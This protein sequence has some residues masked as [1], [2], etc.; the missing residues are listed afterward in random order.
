MTNIGALS[1]HIGVVLAT[2]TGQNYYSVQTDDS[3]QDAYWAGGSLGELGA[4]ET[5]I[6]MPGTRVIVASQHRQ[7]TAYI[8]GVVPLSWWAGDQDTPQFR[9]AW[10]QLTGM[11]C[12]NPDAS[13]AGQLL[14]QQQF[15]RYFEM[16]QIRDLV[17]G[18]WARTSP[19]TGAGVGVE[20]FR[21][22]L[23]GGPFSG[24]FCY[25]DEQA[26]RL[27]GMN[28]ELWSLL[29][30]VEERRR[31]NALE[32]IERWSSTPQDALTDAVPRRL[33]LSGKLYNGWHDYLAPTIAR[34]DAGGTASPALFHQH[35]ASDGFLSITSATG[36][37]LQRYY[38]VPIPVE[39][40]SEFDATAAV[41]AA[42]Q[43]TKVE[44]LTK[45]QAQLDKPVPP[46]ELA[47]DQPFGWLDYV[48][49]LV[50]DYGRRTRVVT[51]A[52]DQTFVPTSRAD[53]QA[54][55]PD[56]SVQWMGP[57]GS[58]VIQLDT[59]NVG[60]KIRYGRSCFSLLPDGS[61]L[62]EDAHQSQL[63]LSG[64]NIFMSAPH[65]I[66]QYAGRS[67]VQI[68]GQDVVVRANRSLELV[69]NTDRVSIKAE[70]QLSL[71]GGNDGGAEGV[72]VESR[73]T[74]DMGVPGPGSTG[75]IG[76]LVLKSAG[77][78]QLY[79]ASGVHMASPNAIGI[80]SPD[81]TVIVD[82]SSTW[83]KAQNAFMFTAGGSTHALSNN[84]LLMA[85]GASI[86]TDSNLYAGGEGIFGG[87]VVSGG[88]V[89]AVSGCVPDP[90]P[91]LKTGLQQAASQ[92]SDAQTQ[93]STAETTINSTWTT[94]KQAT[95]VLSTKIAQLGFSF[96]T[97]AQRGITSA[98]AWMLPEPHW[99]R[100]RQG[101]STWTE[102]PVVSPRGNGQSTSPL[103][104]YEAWT[105][106][107]RYY[108]SDPW[109]ISN[110]GS[111]TNDQAD[112]NAPA[113]KQAKLDGSILTIGT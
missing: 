113:L 4:A 108:K 32:A 75:H 57:L 29:H 17:A 62:V 96:L 110:D 56:D 27:L 95:S 47:G 52:L 10:P 11:D 70:K 82:S 28:L 19:L 101:G 53:D 67:I 74:S 35:L 78:T 38:G 104:G 50:E 61:V 39:Q 77:A 68:A 13:V 107:A 79:G 66:I 84:S 111:T 15:G 88:S 24:L 65:D 46:G 112:R 105:Q 31:G 98:A 72:L 54:Y 89:A 12:D 97:T 86:S 36:I 58:I 99:A 55:S 90:Q 45:I 37:T 43:L 93:V 69:S 34:P 81:G 25:P 21:T 33:G 71:L 2:G 1:V 48:F 41:D 49:D 73:S 40:A 103:P 100:S 22:W 91:S 63:L 76:S 60:R 26:T 42:P 9:A 59:E 106:D 7:G 44:D 109:I 80:S 87:T 8:L 102:S 6:L 18:E 64:G 14:K 20:L 16:N 85:P 51:G 92:I 23:R 83:F 30:Q 3:Y 5:S 94:I